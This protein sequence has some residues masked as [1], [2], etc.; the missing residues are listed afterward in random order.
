MSLSSFCITSGYSYTDLSTSVSD[1]CYPVNTFSSVPYNLEYSNLET[2]MINEGGDLIWTTWVGDSTSS[3]SFSVSN[4]IDNYVWTSWINVSEQ[5]LDQEYSLGSFVNF[6]QSIEDEDEAEKTAKQLLLELIGE[7]ELKVYEKT[8]RVLVKGEKYDYLLSKIGGVQRIKKDVIED[9]CI[10]LEDKY[11]YPRTDNVIG[12]KLLIEAN[13]E[14]FNEKANV[15]STFTKAG[16]YE[17]PE[18]A[19]AGT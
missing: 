17:I 6:E 14:E 9:L 11:K 2:V 7:K 10:H 13:E 1:Y 8:G 16:D 4:G 19:C 5:F 3:S 18:C 12:L 15:I